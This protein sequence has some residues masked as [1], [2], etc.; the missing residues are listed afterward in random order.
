MRCRNASCTCAPTC[1]CPCVCTQALI[2]G[3]ADKEARDKNGLSPLQVS[4]LSGWQN[5]AELLIQSGASTSVS[6]D[7][8]VTMHKILKYE[9]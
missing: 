1:P 9:T 6:S 2:K 4:L 3:G 5:I 8:I 7:E